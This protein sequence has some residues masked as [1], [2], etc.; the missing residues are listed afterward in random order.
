[1]S[2]VKNVEAFGKLIGI[3]TGLGENYT[4][5]K[6]NLSVSSLTSTFT[7]ARLA[8]NNVQDAANEVA[9]T[10]N[11]REVVFESMRKLAQRV[12]SE[13]K[14]NGVPEQTLSDARALNRK[15]AGY[16]ISRDP[17]APQEAEADPKADHKSRRGRG[18]DFITQVESFTM[19]IKL[20]STA[21][22]YNPVREEL[23][24]ASL[25]ATATALISA[26]ETVNAAYATLTHARRYRNDILYRATDNMVE[27]SRLVKSHVRAMTGFT[28]EAF[29]TVTKIKITIP[30]H[31]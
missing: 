22:K 14:S 25:E 8:L 26:N 11:A 21:Q 19:L 18:S 7:S 16:R 12:V 29:K 10:T 31:V 15:L 4:P 23:K 17:V 24:L 1:M 3:C 6:Q 30:S 20:V 13:L 27:L 2:H 28:G 9:N 5:G